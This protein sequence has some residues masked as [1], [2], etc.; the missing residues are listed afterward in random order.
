MTTV[1]IF[2]EVL[3]IAINNEASTS[4]VAVFSAK[5]SD[6]ENIPPKRHEV[7]KI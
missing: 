7:P 6:A 5:Y 2:N 3:P 1:K 4:T